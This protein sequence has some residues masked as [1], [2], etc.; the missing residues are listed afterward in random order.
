MISD[1]IVESKKMHAGN[2]VRE[3]AKNI[4]G[5]GGGQPFMAIAGGA[6]PDGIPAALKDIKKTITDSLL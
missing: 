5:G 1:N 4:K 6:S 2:I 3:A